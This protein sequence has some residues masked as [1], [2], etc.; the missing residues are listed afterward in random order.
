MSEKVVILGTAHRLREPGKCSPDGRLKEAIYSREIVSELRHKLR[1]Y[2]IYTLVDFE[3]YDLPKNLQSPS[4][5]QERQRELALRVNE[6]NSLCDRYGKENCL[7]V[8]IHVNASGSDGKWHSGN[9][10][11]VCVSP[12]AS[13]NSKKLAEHLAVNAFEHNLRVR[14]PRPGVRYWEQS[15]YVLNRTWCPAVLTENLFQDNK[16]DVDY[17]LS[18]EGRHII[19]RLHLEGILE[20][21][22]DLEKK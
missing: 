2:G 16:D 4:V 19:E 9:G 10:W 13:E 8:S 20:Y 21:L 18:D 3:D 15:L 14:E 22:I 5:S 6:V 7:Y 17:L 12:K 11:Q 1:G